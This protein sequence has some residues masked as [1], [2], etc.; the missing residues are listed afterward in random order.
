VQD[1]EAPIPYD[2]YYETALMAYFAQKQGVFDPEKADLAAKKIH[3]NDLDFKY[4]RT[5]KHSLK[6]D[7]LSGMR[8]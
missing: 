1:Q 6:N 3:M 7:Y 4:G 8:Y 5:Y 2:T